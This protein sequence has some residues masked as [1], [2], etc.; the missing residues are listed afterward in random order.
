MAKIFWCVVPLML[1]VA[2]CSKDSSGPGP[3][4]VRAIVLKQAPAGWVV[5]EDV[6]G[7]VPY[8]HY[9][10]TREDKYRGPRG[11]RVVLMG[12]RDVPFTWV[13]KNHRLE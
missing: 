7:Q 8:G 11:R 10:G 1:L 2:A 13:D 6:L 12:P 9:W 5:V 4:A 3:E